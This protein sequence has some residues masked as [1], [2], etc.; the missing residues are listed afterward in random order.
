MIIVNFDVRASLGENL[1]Y[2]LKTV[3]GFFPQSALENQK[4][5]STTDEQRALMQAPASYSRDLTSLLP[6]QGRPALAK[7]MLLMIDRIEMFEP[8]GGS[9][10]LGIAR[11]AKD[12]DQDEWFFKAHFF[13]DPVQPGSLGIEAM[14]QLL[15]WMMLELGLD[16]GLEKPRFEGIAL[17]EEMTWKYRGQVVPSNN[18]ISSTLEITEIIRDD[19]SVLARANASLWVDDK[20]IYEAENLGMRLIS[21]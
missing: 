10:G 16:T 1:V 20:R 15:Q 19:Q 11:A 12:V 3:F 2:D 7:P 13:Q 8:H 17:G 18:I 14:L 9:A 6:S 21:T 4:G 5:L